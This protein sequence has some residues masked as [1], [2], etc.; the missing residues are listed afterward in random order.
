MLGDGVGK[1]ANGLVQ[2]RRERL[3][4]QLLEASHQGQR[5]AVHAIAMSTDVLALHIVQ[6]VAYLIRR[7]LMVIQE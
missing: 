5:E 7:V 6:H 3:D 4:R 2:R 1:A